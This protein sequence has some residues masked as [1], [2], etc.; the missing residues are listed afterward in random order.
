[1][2]GAIGILFIIIA[3]NLSAQFLLA[4]S[5]VI[6][7]LPIFYFPL[8]LSRNRIIRSIFEK[9]T[10]QKSYSISRLLKFSP[11]LVFLAIGYALFFL[12]QRKLV[13]F[14]FDV[15]F[16][17]GFFTLY[18]SI[19]QMFLRVI[20]K[21][22][23]IHVEF[24]YLLSNI[25][26]FN[27]RQKWL[28]KIFVRL[29][30]KLKNGKISVSHDKLLYY[31]NLA[32]FQYQDDFGV[33]IFVKNTLYKI[34]KW[35]INDEN[36]GFLNSL[37]SI[38]PQSEFKPLEKK[39]ITNSFSLNMPLIIKGVFGLAA[40]VILAIINPTTAQQVISFFERML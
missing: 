22:G 3:I 35:L 4:G 25:S 32:L 1:L 24:I 31:F 8:I 38:V 39:P 28:A 26:D 9:R 17:T 10:N 15:F 12:S 13:S 20:S 6:F 11:I 29:E 34:E 21:K 30:D 2:Y 18:F 16:F 19:Y 40:I 23:E 7:I 33:K 36:T 27:L 5:I 14:Q 37:T